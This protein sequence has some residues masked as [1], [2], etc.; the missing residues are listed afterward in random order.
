M[1]DIGDL[2]AKKILVISQRNDFGD[3]KPNDIGDLTTKRYW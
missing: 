2:T 1:T 3:L